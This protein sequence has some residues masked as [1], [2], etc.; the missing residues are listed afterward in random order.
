MP[1]GC[2]AAIVRVFEKWLV[3]AVTT[4]AEKPAR[5]DSTSP[6]YGGCFISQYT[7]NAAESH[8]SFC[9][10]IKIKFRLYRIE[11]GCDPE[12]ADPAGKKPSDQEDGQDAYMDIKETTFVTAHQKTAAPKQLLYAE[13]REVQHQVIDLGIEQMEHG[14]Q[15]QGGRIAKQRDGHQIHEFRGK[16]GGGG[17]EIGRQSNTFHGKFHPFKENMG[18]YQ[19]QCRQEGH[20]SGEPQRRF[21]LSGESVEQVA[22]GNRASAVKF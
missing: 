19:G 10:E 7:G 11:K 5:H 3:A 22:G 17:I 8:A 9:H 16:G 21:D 15:N 1:T 14:D 6:L 12:Q 20:D 2:C 13:G 18:G 4:T